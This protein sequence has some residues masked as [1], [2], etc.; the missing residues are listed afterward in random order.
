MECCDLSAG[1]NAALGPPG[2]YGR[3]A[4]DNAGKK[5]RGGLESFV[6][7]SQSVFVFDADDIVV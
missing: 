5:G 7:G 6:D 1:E 3:V 4:E 2:F